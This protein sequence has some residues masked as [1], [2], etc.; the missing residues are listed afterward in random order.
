ML[1][2]YTL[3]TNITYE[4]N[5]IQETFQ[6]SSVLSF[7]QKININKKIPFLDVLMDT[8]NINR[9]ITSR[10]LKKKNLQISIPAP[11]ISKVNVPSFIKEQL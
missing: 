10:Y 4:I 3:L 11:S 6:N 8:N 1:T 9:F 2:T 5:T 7:I